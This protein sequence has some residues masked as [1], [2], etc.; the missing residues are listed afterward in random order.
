MVTDDDDQDEE[1]EAPPV[2]A[3][4]SEEEEQ[5][6][7]DPR[8]DLRS[9]LRSN[10][11]SDISE[12]EEQANQTKVP[13]ASSE[14]DERIPTSELTNEDAA[15]DNPKLT[16]EEAAQEDPNEKGECNDCPPSSESAEESEL[17]LSPGLDCL[18]F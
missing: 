4:I 5:A 6:R 14:L 18:R 15:Q 9:S 17:I 13:P 1:N 12:V 11:R 8:S 3:H 10:P 16:N 7:S 2:Q